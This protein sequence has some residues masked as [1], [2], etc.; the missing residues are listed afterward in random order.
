M[1]GTTKL[2][3]TLGILCLLFGQSQIVKAQC[4]FTIY[5]SN[6]VN[7]ICAGDN[8][9]SISILADTSG[10]A[11]VLYSYMLPAGT[12]AQM[13]A[14]T[15]G[16]VKVF[17]DTFSNLTAGTYD[18]VVADETFC[19]DTVQVTVGEPTAPFEI[20]FDSIRHSE[21]GNN[22]YLAASTIGGWS[23]PTS[24]TWVGIDIMGDTIDG[25]PRTF[26]YQ[27]TA[28]PPGTYTACATDSRGCMD[29]ITQILTGGSIFEVSLAT[30]NGSLPLDLGDSIELVA[31]PNSGTNVVYEW[32]PLKDLQSISTLQDSVRVSP[33]E[34]RTYIVKAVDVDRQCAA[35]DEMEITLAG[36]FEPWLPNIFNPSSPNSNNNAFQ[37][38][39]LG[40]EEVDLEIF[41]RKGA[42]IYE[43]TEG[44]STNIE[45]WDG[46]LGNSGEIAVAGKYLYIARIKSVC[47]EVVSKNGGITLLR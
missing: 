35:I 21:C 30:Q 32:F 23:T 42:I 25:Y 24:F 15:V 29:C 10:G 4:G 18:I 3:L 40:I 2:L 31:T 16:G 46:T 33:C 34:D 5:P 36:R 28:L 1:Q 44:D 7:V 39:G 41:D 19:S 11:A 9:G 47:G 6:A 43:S 12:P 38:F 8:N 45:M 20:V 37:A 13:E 14:T 22:G 27:N 17:T 26:G